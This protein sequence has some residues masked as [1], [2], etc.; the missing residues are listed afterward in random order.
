MHYNIHKKLTKYVQKYANKPKYSRNCAA[1]MQFL[2]RIFNFFESK[3]LKHLFLLRL[4][5]F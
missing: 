3:T 4:L 2:P 1:K 5:L